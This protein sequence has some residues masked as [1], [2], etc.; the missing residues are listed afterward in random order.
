MNVYKG[1]RIKSS[2]VYRNVS[3]ELDGKHITPFSNEYYIGKTNN[4]I[5]IHNQDKGQTTIYPT[6]KMTYLRTHIIKLDK[7]SDEN[8]ALDKI[9]YWIKDKLYN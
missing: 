3:I 2:I 7:K 4:Y 1:F 8:D 5:F 6:S 9:L